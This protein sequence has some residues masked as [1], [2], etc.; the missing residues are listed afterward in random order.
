MV[1]CKLVLPG[2]YLDGENLHQ[3]IETH[4]VCTTAGVPTVWLNLFNHMRQHKLG[5]TRLKRLVIGGSAP[6]RSMIAEI[7]R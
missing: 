3:L 6:P 1:G 4:G 5:F 7:E 2:P